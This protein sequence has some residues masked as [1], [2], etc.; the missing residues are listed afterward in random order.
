MKYIIRN[1]QANAI[2]Q[3]QET[4][5]SQCLDA[6]WYHDLNTGE[7]ISRN[8]G[9]VLALIHS[10]ISEALEGWRKNLMDDHLPHRKMVEVEFA[11]AVIRI[12]DTAQYHGL[13]VA[14]AMQ[15]KFE[16]NQRREDH[17]IE[18]RKQTNGKKI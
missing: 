2:R 5:H 15:E 13:D 10:E 11:D 17:K 1:D 8:F 4:I 16:Y 3:I 7:A 18:N 14:G 6:G 9:E 12:L